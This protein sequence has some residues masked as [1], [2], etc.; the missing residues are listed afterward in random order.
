MG[1]PVHLSDPFRAFSVN[2]KLNRDYLVET[3]PYFA[4]GAGLSI[5]RPDDR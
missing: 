5:R 3:A 4:V 2:R 1:V